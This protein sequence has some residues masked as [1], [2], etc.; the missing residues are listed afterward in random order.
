MGDADQDAVI[1]DMEDA[2]APTE[3]DQRTSTLVFETLKAPVLTGTNRVE[4][5]AFE[6]KEKST[7][8]SMRSRTA[9]TARMWSPRP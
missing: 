5:I 1:Y 6:M 2:T 4:L 9:T 3:H 8:S 7:C